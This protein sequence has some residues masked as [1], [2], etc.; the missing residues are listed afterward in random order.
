MT[1]TPS[2]RSAAALHAILEATADGILAVDERGELFAYNERFLEL[3]RIPR[4]L[5]E[6]SDNAALLAFV[7]EQLLDPAAFEGTVAINQRDPEGEHFATLHFKDGRVYERCSRPQT[8]G[9]STIGRVISFRDVTERERLLEHAQEALRQRDDFLALAAHEIRTPISSIHLAM[10]ALRREDVAPDRREAL[11]EVVER[12]HARLLALVGDLHEVAKLRSGQAVPL[13][14]APVDLVE[15]VRAVI[16]RYRGEIDDAG[17]TLTVAMP[18]ELVGT[19]DAQRLDQV[20]SNLLS[21]ALK[22]GQGRPVRVTASVRGAWAEL[23]VRDEGIGIKEEERERLFSQFER[24]VSHRQFGGLGL[25]LYI[26]KTIVSALGG[27][28]DVDSA[29]GS[30]ATF[31]VRLPLARR[32]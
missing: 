6:R 28:I 9:G 32:V 4:A 26:A 31:V 23:S 19:W 24:G 20:V 3:W 22:F 18:D 12:E 16:A 13:H 2:A 25:G 5:A 30:G 15:T 29:P 8:S 7:R 21:N 1:P 17:T 14:L 10:Q 11:F 27:V